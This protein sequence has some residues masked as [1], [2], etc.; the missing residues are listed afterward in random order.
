[1]INRDNWKLTKEFLRDRYKY[2]QLSPKSLRLEETWLRYLLEWAREI[3]FDHVDNKNLKFTEYL[4][5]A[6]L[7]GEEKPFSTIYTKKVLATSRRFFIWLRTKKKGYRNKIDSD[8]ISTLKTQR[9]TYDFKEHEAIDLE[10]VIAISKAP[11]ENMREKRIRAAA[12]FWFL[13]GIRIGAFVT[14][15]I[16]A[17]NL[18]E[19]SIKQFTSL[20]V[21]TKF[22]KNE[23]TY[24]LNIPGL[25]D[26]VKDWDDL[27]R[28][29]LSEENYWFAPL[30][31]ET[32]WFDK[33][34]KEAGNNRTS[35]AYK[36]LKE[37]L[38]KVGLPFHS[39][40]KFRHGHAV[41]SIKVANTVAELKAISQNLMHSNLSIT[42]GIYG[43]LS[44]EDRKNYITNLGKK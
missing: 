20:G 5:S 40:H 36:D 14:L 22:G 31:P 13:S 7:N 15:P 37:W 38:E 2:D 29:N 12:V 1:M 33:D 44:R 11:V 32:C 39:P 35:R 24:L 18:E 8:F 19:S 9:F 28:K 34:I 4:K 23:T 10:E 16:R 41:Y 6:R 3:T 26:V 21:K 42:D 25:I 17:I 30:S 43:I 27:V